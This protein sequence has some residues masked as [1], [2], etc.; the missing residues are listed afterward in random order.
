[1]LEPEVVEEAMAEEVMEE[2]A[3]TVVVDSPAG[4]IPLVDSMG[5]P[6][7]L[8]FLHGLPLLSS[9]CSSSWLSDLFYFSRKFLLQ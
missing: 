2:E 8:I 3:G 7:I 1:M 5:D 6:A 9:L 4:D